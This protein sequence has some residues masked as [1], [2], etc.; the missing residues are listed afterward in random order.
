MSTLSKMLRLS[1]LNSLS[2][3]H[4]VEQIEAHNERYILNLETQISYLNSELM[5]L[6][7]RYDKLADA[8]EL[9]CRRPDP[10]I[11]CD[12]DVMDWGG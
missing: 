4:N 12:A 5:D 2:T 7:L 3:C 11:W 6:G 9:D 10:N 1:P 8:Y